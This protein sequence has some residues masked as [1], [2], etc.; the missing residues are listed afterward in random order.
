VNLRVDRWLAPIYNVSLDEMHRLLP[1][2]AIHVLTL[3]L[4]GWVGALLALTGRKA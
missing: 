3:L 2:A 4:L 1:M